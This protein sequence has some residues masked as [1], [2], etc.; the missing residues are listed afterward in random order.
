MSFSDFFK[1]KIVLV[2]GHTGFKGAWLS[3]WLNEMGA[4]VIGYSLEPPYAN[5][6]FEN[7]KL[8][9][10]LI[11][12][13]SDIRDL[14]KLETIFKKYKPEIIF[15]LAAQPIVRVSYDIPRD[16]FEIN[17]MGTINVLECLR[18]Y[19]YK[20]AVII[21]SD[22]CYENMENMEGYVETDRFSNKD[23]YSSSKGCA[24]LVVES[25]RNY[26]RMEV[27]TARAGNVV[28]GGDWAKDRLVPDIMRALK[29][30]KDIVVRNPESVRP[31]QFVLESLH[32]YLILAQKQ[33]AGEDVNEGWNFGP[34]RNSMITVKELVELITKKWGY[35]DVV[36]KRDTSKPEAGLLYLNCAKSKARLGW[37]PK[38][39]IRETIKYIVE[40]YRNY[41]NEDV[42]GL[43][44]KQ[45][46]EYEDLK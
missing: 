10:K 7:A 5:S 35:G 44:A 1:G 9:D 31:W 13:R 4:K 11:D 45:I 29:L 30:K 38:I 3:I 39:D 40:W 36:I 37:K 18:K 14:K 6:L 19:P 24:E 26:F 23:P 8:K 20:S 27:A 25:Y 43:C 16:T 41:E 2:T 12:I 21:T 32:G 17:I 28:G 34:D 42:Y 33:Y 22:K 46:R 15:H